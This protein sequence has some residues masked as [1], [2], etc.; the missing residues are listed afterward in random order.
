MSGDG[1]GK[2]EREGDIEGLGE[3]DAKGEWDA[4]ALAIADPLSWATVAVGKAEACGEADREPLRV[5][6]AASFLLAL[7][8]GLAPS[9]D[10]L[11]GKVTVPPIGLRVWPT[12]RVGSCVPSDD[13]E[14]LGERLGTLPV[15]LRVRAPLR[16]PL[17]VTV[18]RDVALLGPG[19]RVR[20]CKGGEGDTGGV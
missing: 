10:A 6:S 3:E 17:P 9:G 1:E 20:V 18:I 7:V 8:V 11:C 13:P 4:L 12:E 5:P 15:A 19:L 16:V 2:G 14:G